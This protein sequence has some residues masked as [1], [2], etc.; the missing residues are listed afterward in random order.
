MIHAHHGQMLGFSIAARAGKIMFILRDVQ[1]ETYY[2]YSTSHFDLPLNIKIGGCMLLFLDIGHM[3][4]VI[5]RFGLLFFNGR[6]RGHIYS[7]RY[8]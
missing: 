6:I 2:M 4:P 3:H 8:F 1:L 5:R 7:E